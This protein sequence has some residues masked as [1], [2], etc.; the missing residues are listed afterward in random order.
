MSGVCACACEVVY[1]DGRTEFSVLRNFPVGAVW[2]VC[3]VRRFS[4]CSRWS[5]RRRPSVREK[6]KRNRDRPTEAGPGSVAAGV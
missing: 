1:D 2:L 3:F 6:N 4:S 5:R